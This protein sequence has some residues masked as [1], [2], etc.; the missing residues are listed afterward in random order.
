MEGDIKQA[1]NK[2]DKVESKVLTADTEQIEQDAKAAGGEQA[3]QDAD[4]ED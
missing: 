3:A 2:A 1:M 4:T